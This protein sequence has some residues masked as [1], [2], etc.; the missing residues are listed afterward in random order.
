MKNQMVVKSNFLIEASYKLSAPEQRVILFLVSM[1]NPNDEDFREYVFPIKDFAKMAGI[2]HKQEYAQTEEITKSLI[3]RAFTIHS[4]KGRLQISWL[5]SAEYQDGKGAVS[6]KFDSKLKPFLLQLKER[7]TKYGIEQVMRLKSSYSI[8]IYELLKQYEKFGK[9]IFFMEDLRS[10]LGISYSKYPR[11]GNLKQRV[12]SIAQEEIAEKTDLSYDF[13]EIKVGRG[14]GKIRFIINSKA[15]EKN[16]ITQA[17]P[18]QPIPATPESDEI[19]KLIALLPAEYRGKESIKRLIL[20]SFE[21]HGFDYV[22]R[23]IEYA[24]DGSNAVKPGVSLGKGSNYRVYLAKALVG[25]F[26][27]PSREDREANQA[28]E[29]KARQEQ[30]AAALAMRQAQEKIQREQ[31]NKDRARVYRESLSPEALEA[32]KEEALVRMDPAHRE[33][34]NRKATGSVILL[35]IAIDKLCLERMKLA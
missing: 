3:G 25:D 17:E 20:S 30:K 22:A 32:L 15:V 10:K 14:V 24:N 23:N 34:L 19:S 31:E 28:Q 18:I 13:E 2:K 1:I 21:K 12:L 5:S 6:L 11:Y 26:G 4:P 29:E 9:R 27:L 16:Q 33:A 35:R 8:R 7:F